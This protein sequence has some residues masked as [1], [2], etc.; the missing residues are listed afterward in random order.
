MPGTATHT[1]QQL[2]DYLFG[3]L[4]PTPADSQ[5]DDRADLFQHGMDSLRL[6]QLLVFIEQDLGVK[7]PDDEVTQERLSTVN[8]I[9]E[10][11]D[12]HRGGRAS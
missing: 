9:V 2:R 10:W 8:S 7:L 12:R 5:P 11:V 4:I 1:R 6:M 3:S